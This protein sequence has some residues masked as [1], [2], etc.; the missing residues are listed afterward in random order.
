MEYDTI[1][2][3]QH[4]QQ[5]ENTDSLV[6]RRINPKIDTILTV[7]AFLLLIPTLTVSMFLLLI[8]LGIKE[9]FAKT[10]LVENVATKENFRVKK[11]EWSQYKKDCKRKENEV[12]TI[13]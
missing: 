2:S 6:L 9:F 11:M 5:I 3:L 7:I 1:A 8:Y 12:K 13:L 4:I 10:Y